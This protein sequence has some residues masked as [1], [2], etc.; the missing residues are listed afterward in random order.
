VNIIEIASEE[1][2]FGA[3]S[4]PKEIKEKDF[5]LTHQRLA[6]QWLAHPFALRFFTHGAGAFPKT[7]FA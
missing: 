4:Q 5:V 6:H 3:Y 7:N 1:P 2:K